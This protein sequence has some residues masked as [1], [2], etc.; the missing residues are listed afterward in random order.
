MS[1]GFEGFADTILSH[2]R[3]V[4]VGSDHVTYWPT[5]DILLQMRHITYVT[6][7]P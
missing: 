5:D 4:A 7:L 6:L 2:F 1:E 3:D